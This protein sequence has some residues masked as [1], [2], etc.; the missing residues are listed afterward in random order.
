MIINTTKS[1]DDDDDDDYCQWWLASGGVA[2][3]LIGEKIET[4]AQ[5]KSACKGGSFF[6][7]LRC[8]RMSR[9]SCGFY[10]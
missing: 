10:Q 8:D 1:S 6:F 3:A 2:S 4:Q 5:R 9:E 7:S